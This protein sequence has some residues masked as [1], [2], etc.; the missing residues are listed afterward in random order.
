MGDA[1]AAELG[2]ILGDG[3]MYFQPPTRGSLPPRCSNR[4]GEVS[5]KSLRYA[6]GSPLLPAYVLDEEDPGQKGLGGPR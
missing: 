2:C 4:C 3:E 6:R 5:T 1:R